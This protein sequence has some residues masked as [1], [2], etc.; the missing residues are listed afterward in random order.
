MHEFIKVDILEHGSI[1]IDFSLSANQPQ[2][3]TFCYASAIYPIFLSESQM[4]CLTI[5]Q[6]RATT[7]LIELQLNTNKQIFW[8]E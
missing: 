8:S 7:I 4:H 5:D 6:K 2:S 1:L 3:E